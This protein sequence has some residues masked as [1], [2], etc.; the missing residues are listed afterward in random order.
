MSET[1]EQKQK[2]WLRACLRNMLAPSLGLGIA[3]LGWPLA[4]NGDICGPR[5]P[6]PTDNASL[7]ALALFIACLAVL[8]KRT[9]ETRLM[10]SRVAPVVGALVQ[11]VS[12]AALGGFHLANAC[13]EASRTV[14]GALL[15]VSTGF[16]LTHWLGRARELSM[17][18]AT[19]YVFTA[20]G[21]SAVLLFVD[22]F[23]PPGLSALACS[24]LMVAQI[25]LQAK[26]AKMTV[27]NIPALPCD[28]YYSL[29]HS[30][31]TDRKF[32]VTFAAGLCM[33]VL[34]S[35]FLDT[36]PDDQ[37]RPLGLVGNLIA[38]VLALCICMGIVVSAVRRQSRVMTVGIWVI[39]ELLAAFALVLYNAFPDDLWIGAA[40]SRALSIVMVGAVFHFTISL[41]SSGWRQPLY[42]ACA[43]WVI[44]FGARDVG[45][46]ML[47]VLPVGG[48]SHLTGAVV[49]LLL[50]VS[51]QITLVKLIDLGRDAA[52]NL[53]D[54]APTPAAM[55]NAFERFLG[56]D[57]E[58]HANDEK[59]AV[60]RQAK[61]VGEQ[62]LL[63]DREVEV[64]ALYAMGHTQKRVAEELFISPTTAHTHIT[65]I[66]AKT[67]LH[68]RQELLD[69]M[70]EYASE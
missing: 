20:L 1:K 57:E 30:V 8:Q 53:G 32:L 55:P 69:Y 27:D 54:N 36:F 18:A 66:Y 29:M 5:N 40:V 51:T 14:L 37:S 13:T 3:Y 67:D 45:R 63:S 39:M 49:S 17:P 23:L 22:S 48:N 16:M 31:S 10:Q 34:V 52:R 50:L 12:L 4:V 7:V 46:L 47:A 11:V 43:S 64:L 35:G 19:V 58:L 56:L 60:K 25:P 65:R 42:Y 38:C 28:D 21:I 33:I 9:R 15:T 2:A 59:D 44:W 70:S 62:F 41:M 68:S 26:S 61:R 24:A 6:L